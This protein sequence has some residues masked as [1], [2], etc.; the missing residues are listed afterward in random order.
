MK[1]GKKKVKPRWKLVVKGQGLAFH[2]IFSFFSNF[3]DLR[4][5]LTKTFKHILK[6]SITFAVALILCV[7]VCACG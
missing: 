3:G 6:L 5:Y 4:L 2:L 1:R 7:C